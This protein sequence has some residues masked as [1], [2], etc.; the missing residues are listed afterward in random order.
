MPV[1]TRAPRSHKPANNNLINSSRISKTPTGSRPATSSHHRAISPHIK[2]K[3]SPEYSYTTLRGKQD[4]RTLVVKPGG[5][6]DPIYFSLAIADVNDTALKYEA[7]SYT[8]GDATNRVEVKCDGCRMCITRSLFD[9][10][11]AFRKPDIERR[12][13]ADAVCINQ[14]H[15]EERNQQVS[16]MR[17]IYSRAQKVL[18][19]VGDEDDEVVKAGLDLICKLWYGLIEEEM[20]SGRF[21]TFTQDEDMNG[22]STGG[23]ESSDSDSGESEIDIKK[24]VDRDETDSG[25]EDEAASNESESESDSDGDAEDVDWDEGTPAYRWKDSLVRASRRTAIRSTQIT[26]DHWRTIWPLYRCTW[27]TRVWIIQEVV[28][29]SSATLHWGKGAINF[30]LVGFVAYFIQRS[31]GRLRPHSDDFS[32]ENASALFQLLKQTLDFTFLDNVCLTRKCAV[33]D[34]RDRIFGLLGLPT[35]D[36]GPEREDLF[37]SPDYALSVSAVYTFAAEKWLVEQ[38]KF[39]LLSQV[40]HIPTIPID[41]PSWVPNWN[42]LGT[43]TILGPD[44]NAMCSS[45]TDIRKSICEYSNCI[46]VKGFQWGTVSS[47]A[48]TDVVR[49]VATKDRSGPVAGLSVQV[50]D[51]FKELSAGFSRECLAWTLTVG[52][53]CLPN[54]A[55][56]PESHLTEHDAF[57]DNVKQW[58]AME[59]LSSTLPPPPG[60]MY[61]DAVTLNS[62]YRRLFRTTDGSLGNG[63]IAM[64]EG[65]VVCILLGGKVPYVLRPVDDH[66]R[67]VGECYVH[68][69]MNGELA[70]MRNDNERALSVF[71]IY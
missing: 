14:N 43:T 24:E 65:D 9:A 29:A 47:V 34:P 35:T 17:K 20:E 16:L 12:L 52:A 33:T 37:L 59:G 46:A 11:R 5:D 50:S 10:L 15:L 42:Q 27:F 60:Y 3:S 6:D 31:S 61:L 26:Q 21:G 56:S 40:Q 23:N 41:I 70:R 69:I 32:F 19:W 49:L 2:A 39:E 53:H 36:T 22:S 45:P 7:I 54:Q 48:Q 4:I 62:R 28:L 51:D 63:P 66:Y 44:S 68:N 55:D 57:V 1:S 71:H 8:W 67:F 64:A 30:E 18:I 58:S 13:W 25:D 38:K